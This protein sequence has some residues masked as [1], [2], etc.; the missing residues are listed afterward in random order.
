MTALDETTLDTH[1][2]AARMAEATANAAPPIP[3][4]LDT[5]YTQQLDWRECRRKLRCAELTVD[6][7]REVLAMPANVAKLR[8]NGR[9]PFDA[10]TTVPSVPVRL[11][12]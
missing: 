3:Q 8:R 5:F 11:K 10:P 9:T 1:A 12:A 7:Y 4:R 2:L 6:Q